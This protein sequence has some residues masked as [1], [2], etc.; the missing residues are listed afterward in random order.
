[1]TDI[2]SARNGG[3]I[4]VSRNRDTSDSVIDMASTSRTKAATEARMRA[5]EDKAA[6]RLMERGWFCVRMDEKLTASEGMA[7]YATNGLR[8]TYRVAGFLPDGAPLLRAGDHTFIGIQ[9]YVYSL[10]PA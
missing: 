1:M 9:S 10:G 4:D 2:G 5:S 3:R 6:R 7:L 8:E